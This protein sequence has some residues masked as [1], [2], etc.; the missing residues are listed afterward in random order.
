MDAVLSDLEFDSGRGS[1][2]MWDSIGDFFRNNTALIYGGIAGLLIRLSYVK[3][4]SLSQW[5]ITSSVG[6]SAAF[7]AAEELASALGISVR[8]SAGLCTILGEEA[9]KLFMTWLQKTDVEKIVGR[10]FPTKDDDG[11]R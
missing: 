6:L 7:L 2:A 10:Y 5:V 8:L 1:W 3:P 11:K 4:N 9:V